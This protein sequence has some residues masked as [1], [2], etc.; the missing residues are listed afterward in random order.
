MKIILASRCN[1]IIRLWIHNIRIWP[2][3]VDMKICPYLI[4][5]K[6]KKIATIVSCKI[7]GSETCQIFHILP[8]VF[9]LSFECGHFNSRVQRCFCFLLICEAWAGSRKKKKVSL[10]PG[11]RL[12]TTQGRGP[13][14]YTNQNLEADKASKGCRSANF[15]KIIVVLNLTKLLWSKCLKTQTCMEIVGPFIAPCGGGLWDMGERGTA[16]CSFKF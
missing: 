3:R 16:Y 2:I 6:K 15:S 4:L 10:R 7:S 8:P 5:K 11:T 1:L 14:V 13:L 12:P 9:Q